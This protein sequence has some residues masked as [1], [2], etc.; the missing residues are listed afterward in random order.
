[1]KG[2]TVILDTPE[3][4]AA[5]LLLAEKYELSPEFETFRMYRGPAPD[6]PLDQT[7]GITTF[8]LG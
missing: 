3:P 7:F 2:R 8:E 6:L 5:A 1:M 4:N